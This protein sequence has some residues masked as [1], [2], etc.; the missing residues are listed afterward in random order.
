MKNFIRF[1]ALTGFALLLLIVSACTNDDNVSPEPGNLTTTSRTVSGFSGLSIENGIQATIVKGT[2]EGVTIEAREGYQPYI[3]TE[4]VN[5]V[6][7]IRIDDRLESSRLTEK[8]AMVTMKA[9]T[10]LTTSGGAR[11]TSTDNFQPTNLALTVNGGGFVNLLLTANVLSINSSGGS[12]IE[13]SGTAKTVSVSALS[14]GGTLRLVNLPAAT[15]TI[16]A[17]GGSTAEL[18]VSQELN[19]TASGGSRIRYRGTPKITQNLSGGST[20]TQ[21]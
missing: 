5:G 17:S 12:E 8:R 16:D 1:S 4:V 21:F 2:T 19:I 6:L 20:L 18:N 9:L 11:V 7:R 14:G 13:L 15:C 10:N 3:L